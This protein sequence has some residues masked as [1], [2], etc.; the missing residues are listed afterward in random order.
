MVDIDTFMNLSKSPFPAR[1]T[2]TE[3]IESAQETII[4]SGISI[5][6]ATNID[7]GLY[8]CIKD[9]KKFNDT[10]KI[11]FLNIKTIKINPRVT[12]LPCQRQT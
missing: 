8:P 12:L 2:M 9:Q 4:K 11:F 1:V 5:K 7:L 10:K 3:K 6:E